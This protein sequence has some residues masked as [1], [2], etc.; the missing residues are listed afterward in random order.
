MRRLFARRLA[1]DVTSAALGSR[2]ARA[3]AVG[4]QDQDP[5]CYAWAAET[6]GQRGERKA[7]PRERMLSAIR[8]EHTCVPF[9]S[10]TP[11]ICRADSGFVATV[12]GPWEH[13][14]LMGVGAYSMNYV[15]QYTI[16]AQEVRI[17]PLDC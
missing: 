2:G 3:G 1:H 11:G 16:R 5:S 4:G 10:S 14:I 17:W 8:P 15:G 6:G 7:A 9:A 13:M 12:A